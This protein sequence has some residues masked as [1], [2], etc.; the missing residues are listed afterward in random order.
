L[1]TDAHEV[2]AI[3]LK[4]EQLTVDAVEEVNPAGGGTDPRLAKSEM[5]HALIPPP[6]D[7]ILAYVKAIVTSSLYLQTNV[8]MEDIVA[9][10]QSIM[11]SDLH[12]TCP[13]FWHHAMKDPV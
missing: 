7:E 2:N 10:V 3:L 12:P 1:D 4:G 6:D 8:P 5:N 13:K 11:A 9:F